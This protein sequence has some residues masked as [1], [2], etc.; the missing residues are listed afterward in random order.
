MELG[1]RVFLKFG[2]IDGLV[3][4]IVTKGTQITHEQMDLWY[5]PEYKDDLYTY[6]KTR[7]PS[8]R[9]DRIVIIDGNGN[10]YIT[11]IGMIDITRTTFSDLGT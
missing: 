10:H 3:V 5:P 2:N 6:N 8:F 7:S 11:S 9:H 1:T 4:H